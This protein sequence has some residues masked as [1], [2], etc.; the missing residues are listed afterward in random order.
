M[1]FRSARSFLTLIGL[2]LVLAPPGCSKSPTGILP[3]DAP[4][5]AATAEA[6]AFTPPLQT[7]TRPPPASTPFPVAASAGRLEATPAAPPPAAPV[8]R[9]QA[10]KQVFTGNC[11][12][13][14]GP[15]GEGGIGPAL[16]GAGQGLAKYPSAQSLLKFVQSSMPLDAPG[17]LREEDY[18]D[19]LAFIL[20]G[21]GIIA[22]DTLNPEEAPGIKLAK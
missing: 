1:K 18:W 7:T 8:G 16:I 14:H 10:G 6:P 20:Q 13:C 22:A 9:A 17:S 19:V 12:G 2:L 21:N 11:S 4:S 5:P 15:G 3:P